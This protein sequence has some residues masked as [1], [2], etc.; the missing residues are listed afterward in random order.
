MN[1]RRGGVL[2][3]VDSDAVA[4]QP[5]ESVLCPKGC[6]QPLA[7]D[8]SR[9]GALME[10]CFACDPRWRLTRAALLPPP[11]RHQPRNRALRSSARRAPTR[12]TS[13]GERILAAVPFGEE[14][15]VS[16]TAIAARARA[17]QTRSILYG[18]W[19]AGRIQRRPNPD[20]ANGRGFLYW[21][22]WRV[23]A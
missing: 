13:R 9:E 18:L 1:A 20:C 10:R 7:F 8:T 6:G 15:A 5:S 21:R 14:H 2:V 12:L 11:P 16:T 4:R 23:A 19:K 17:S 3:T 22:S